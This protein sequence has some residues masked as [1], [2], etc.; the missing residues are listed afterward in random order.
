MRSRPRPLN[1][2][3]RHRCRQRPVL[4][5]PASPTA[6]P[7]RRAWPPQRS[8]PPPRRPLRRCR[9]WRRRWWWGTRC[10]PAA[11]SSLP[12]NTPVASVS[13]VDG[14]TKTRSAD[15]SAP[16]DAGHPG[17]SCRDLT[18]RVLTLDCALLRDS[19]EAFMAAGRVRVVTPS[20][21][22]SERG[23]WTIGRL[24]AAGKVPGPD[25]DAVPLGAVCLGGCQR[26]RHRRLGRAGAVRVGDAEG[27]LGRR[28]SGRPGSERHEYG[29]RCEGAAHGSR[30]RPRHATGKLRRSALGHAQPRTRRPRPRGSGP[31]RSCG[32]ST[33]SG[34]ARRLS[35]ARR[36]RARRRSG[37][38]HR[39]RS[40]DR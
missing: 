16:D 28:G 17:L 18:I 40:G 24:P 25:L 6:G 32:S 26:I 31:S 23:W 10:R 27:L 15:A 5:V 21:P 3:A 9:H 39:G 35:P 37:A 13:A 7:G 22:R 8:T 30:L 34:S 12:T 14:R 36:S 11:A 1:R 19:T 2:R 4:P 20:A 33:R 29:D 38:A